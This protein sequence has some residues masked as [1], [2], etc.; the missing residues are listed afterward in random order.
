MLGFRPTL[1]SSGNGKNLFDDLLRLNSAVNSGE[2]DLDR[3]KLLVRAA[4]TDIPDDTVIWNHLYEAVTE[5]TPPPRPIP[6]SIQQTPL[7]QNT[8]GLVISSEFRQDVDPILKSELGPLYAG[9][10]NFHKVFF[11][12]VSD[13][14]R[15]SE[16][17]FRRCTEGDHL[18]FT[19]GWT[20]WPATAKESDVVA[21]FGGIIP[22][23]EAFAS[24]RIPTPTT[25]RKLLAQPRT[26][27]ISSTGK[28]SMDIG[29]VNSDIIYNL[30]SEDSRYRWSYILVAG[31]LKSNPKADTASIV[32][33]D[34]ARYV[35]EI[36][37]A[38][39]DR[40]FVLGF[41]L[42]G[43]LMRVW[44]FDRLGGVASEQ[45]DIN[46]EDGGLRFVMTILGFLRMNE[47]MLGFDPTIRASGDEKYI[48][49]ERND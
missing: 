41:T 28:R 49:I 31:E 7:S 9:L 43:S 2:F 18:L 10:P 33:I 4:I 3:I 37:G 44:E 38:Q 1:R 46:K 42:C 45:F 20:E 6:S 34:L 5:S 35:R 22:K 30:D 26:P 36:F 11:G 40:R 27:L 25:R 47:E 39:E 23:L 24:D 15:V 29:F 21:W 32:W 14:D 48:D 13:L 16:T 12:D 8:S 19:D 17:V